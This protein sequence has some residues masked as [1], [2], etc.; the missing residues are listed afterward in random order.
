MTFRLTSSLP[1]ALHWPGLASLFV[2]F[3]LV[4][5][6]GG[7]GS[8]SSNPQPEPSPP[9][10]VPN[11]PPPAPPPVVSRSSVSLLAGT[12]A[13]FGNL[14]GT[15]AAARFNGLGG[16]AL[17]SAGNLYVADYG[18]R[19]V[20]KVTPAGV[21]ST[22]AGNGVGGYGDGAG[23]V[24]TFCGPRDVAI[25]GNDN[26]FVLDNVVV[27]KISADGR[28]TTLTKEVPANC[29]ITRPAAPP[30]FPRALAVTQS[31]VLYV[32]NQIPTEVYRVAPT[33][34]S[35]RLEGIDQPTAD[36]VGAFGQLLDIAVDDIGN[37]YVAGTVGL[38][39][40]AIRKITPA[41]QITTVVAAA[42]DVS[43]PV[44]L[45]FG[46]N[47]TLYFAGRPERSGPCRRAAPSNRSLSD[48]VPCT[49][50]SWS[51]ADGSIWVNDFS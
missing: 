22:V 43:A 46:R 31:G 1:T 17:D 38:G 4:G 2:A 51:T 45:T 36:G 35:V 10:V 41:G 7:G 39:P 20:R 11:P 26:V 15:G 6:G 37:L 28:V 23:N 29:D 49:G 48:I 50:Q 27:R 9:P 24:A 19:K 13:G 14:D 25:D 44:Q 33:G 3:A 34:E 30:Q 16:A 18:S 8:D 21:V 40:P 42:A 12:T 47:G 5:C 32:A